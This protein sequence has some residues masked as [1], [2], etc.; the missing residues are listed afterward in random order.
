MSRLGKL[1]CFYL[2][3]RRGFIIALLTGYYVPYPPPEEPRT[4]PSNIIPL[5]YTKGVS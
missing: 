3:E 1:K 2:Y 4:K 5:K